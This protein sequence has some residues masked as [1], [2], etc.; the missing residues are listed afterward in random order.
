MAQEVKEEQE[1]E[2]TPIPP[3]ID[4]GSLSEGAVLISPKTLGN[5]QPQVPKKDVKTPQHAN[6]P[7]SKSHLTAIIITFVIV[8]LVGGVLYAVSLK[9]KPKL[10]QESVDSMPQVQEEEPLATLTYAN[11]EYGFSFDYLNAFSIPEP[12]ENIDEQT[13]FQ[14][15]MHFSAFGRDAYGGLVSI[16]VTLSDNTQSYLD[17]YETAPEVNETSSSLGLVSISFGGELPGINSGEGLL[18]MV[19]IFPLD[20]YFVEIRYQVSDQIDVQTY[21]MQKQVYNAIVE[22]F[23]TVS[24]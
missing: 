16:I 7:K 24:E 6:E 4:R 2:I 14:Q 11:T 17:K 5:R 9:K 19:T 12:Q 18:E 23:S 20:D 13:L 21:D 10:N 1:E 8:L 22:S 3:K 15:N